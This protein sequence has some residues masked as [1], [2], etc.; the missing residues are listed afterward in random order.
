VDLPEWQVGVVAN[1]GK[2]SALSSDIQIAEEQKAAT[3]DQLEQAQNDRS[4][5][6][7]ENLAKSETAFAALPCIRQN[8]LVAISK[9]PFPPDPRNMSAA[10]LGTSSSSGPPFLGAHIALL[11]GFNSEVPV[12][13]PLDDSSEEWN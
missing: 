12:V 10:I 6:I 13:T 4:A 8:L 2:S 7:R 1:E 11:S 3:K 5:A 9:E